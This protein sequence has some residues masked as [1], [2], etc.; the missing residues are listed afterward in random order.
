M[1]ELR[2]NETAIAGDLPWSIKGE[3]AIRDARGYLVANMHWR[4]RKSNAALIVR[5]VNAHAQLVEALEPFA[6][7]TVTPSG[8]IVGLAREHINAARAALASLKESA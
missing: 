4:N 7:V 6:T 1:S 2:F 3:G 8:E 5:A